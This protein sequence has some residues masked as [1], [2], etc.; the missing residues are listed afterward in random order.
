[1]KPDKDNDYFSYSRSRARSRYRAYDKA[2][3]G[4]YFTGSHVLDIERVTAAD[5][6]TYKVEVYNHV[7]SVGNEA[8]IELRHEGEKKEDFTCNN[9]SDN[10]FLLLLL[11]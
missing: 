7:R 5:L 3:Y 2:Y 10:K 4:N 1:M 8:I 11:K 6:G 9:F